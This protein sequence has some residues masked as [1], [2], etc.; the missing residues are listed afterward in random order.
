MKQMLGISKVQQ[1]VQDFF[2]LGELATIFTN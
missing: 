1:P 2:V